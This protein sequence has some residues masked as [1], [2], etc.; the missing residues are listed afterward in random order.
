ML[1]NKF[2]KFGLL[3]L[4]AIALLL[5]FT[6]WLITS[7]FFLRKVVLP[8]VGDA[9]GI[10]MSAQ[11]INLSLLHSSVKLTGIRVGKEK[12]PLAV[13]ES[14]QG[15]FA[16]RKILSGNIALENVI[17]ERADIKISKTADGVWNLPGQGKEKSKLDTTPEKT[18]EKNSSSS[19]IDLNLKNIKINNSSVTLNI[20]GS[21]KEVSTLEISNLNVSLPELRNGQSGRLETKGKLKITSGNDIRVSNG[22]WNSSIDLELTDNLMVRKLT[23]MSNIANLGGLVSG[24]TLKNGSVE[25]VVNAAG[26]DKSLTIRNI[27]LRQVRDGKLCSSV[28][29]NGGIIYEPFAVDAAINIDPLSEDIFSIV[30]D[31]VGGVNPGR[32]LLKYFGQVKYVGSR[33]SSSGKL[34]L[35]RSGYAVVAGKKLEVP[36]FELLSEHDVKVNFTESRILL[37]KLNAEIVGNNRR[38]VNMEL[39]KSSEFTWKKG[40]SKFKGLPPEVSFNFDNLDLKIFKSMFLPDDGFMLNGGILNGNI[41]CSTDN[42]AS[43]ISLNG[44]IDGQGIDVKIGRNALNDINFTQSFNLNWLRFKE[45]KLN[46]MILKLKRGAV[47][48]GKLNIKGQFNVNNNATTVSWSLTEIN[49]RTL[50]MLPFPDDLQRELNSIFSKLDAVV[51]GMNGDAEL[52]F[53]HKRFIIKKYEV[54]AVQRGKTVISAQLKPVSVADFNEIIKHSEVNLKFNDLQVKQ[55]NSLLSKSGMIFY[56]GSITSDIVLVWNGDEKKFVIK[57]QAALKNFDFS[58]AGKRYQ[59]VTLAQNG[60]C[61]LV[62]TSSLSIGDTVSEVSV[63]GQKALNLRARGQLDFDKGAG[64]ISGDIVDLNE[65]LLNLFAP[66]EYGETAIKA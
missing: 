35:L 44:N 27:M 40:N 31:F 34:S 60:S 15:S 16:L 9:S 17:L 43:G 6:Y 58:A 50:K 57:Y 53:K 5:L 39:K 22:D 4:T 36:A 42:S 8:M 38:L 52:D 64:E 54:E 47:A 7:S 63:K 33:L 32:V 1:K 23:L 51:I 25:I 61:V 12:S 37:N 30:Y 18:T 46:S 29:V 49:D 10:E 45:L 66:G 62:K 56:A 55:F 48:L 2:V 14:L 11:E 21:G 41:V 26:D 20:A 59:D 28:Q 65:H 19:S 24:I 13:A 3:P